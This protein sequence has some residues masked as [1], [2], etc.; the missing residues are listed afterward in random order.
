MTPPGVLR[1]NLAVVEEKNKWVKKEPH[2]YHGVYQ[3]ESDAGWA[4]HQTLL[5]RLAHG[6]QVRWAWAVANGKSAPA[7]IRQDKRCS[8]DTIY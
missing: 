6:F 8:G 4:G 1:I 5:F 7:G 3:G 2:V